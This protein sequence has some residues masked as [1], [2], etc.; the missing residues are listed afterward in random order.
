MRKK[1]EMHWQRGMGTQRI[2]SIGRIKDKTHYSTSTGLLQPPRTE[3]NRDRRIK[4]RL[5][6]DTVT[7]MPGRKMETTGVPIQHN[8]ERRMQLQHPRQ[9]T[10]SDSSGIP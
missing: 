8:V 10:P 5:L 7:R 9:G 6:R 1:A 3:Q 2:L 4:I